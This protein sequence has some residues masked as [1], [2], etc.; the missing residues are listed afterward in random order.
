MH[1]FTTQDLLLLLQG[2]PDKRGKCDRCEAEDQELWITNYADLDGTIYKKVNG[3]FT[4]CRAC[5]RRL[6]FELRER[7]EYSLPVLD[8][9]TRRL[10]QMFVRFFWYFVLPLVL[11][12]LYCWIRR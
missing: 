10:R 12:G 11:V 4:Y 9:E 1:E 8:A 3:G 5:V 2:P 6:A 7:E